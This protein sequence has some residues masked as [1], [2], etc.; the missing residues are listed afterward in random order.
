MHKDGVVEV[1]A[2]TTTYQFTFTDLLP[3]TCYSL[4][5]VPVK[6]CNTTDLDGSTAT[7][8]NYSGDSITITECTGLYPAYIGNILLGMRSTPV[9]IEWLSC[10]IL[11]DSGKILQ[12]DTS[13]CKIFFHNLARSCKITLCLARILQHN[14][15]SCK[16]L[17]DSHRLAR[18]CKI[19]IFLQDRAR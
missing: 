9:D 12:D 1:V 10:K 5:V 8:S 6:Y 4:E 18:S 19:T 11:Q 16:I 7:A 17:Q 15:S 13:S 14:H 2:G 3:G